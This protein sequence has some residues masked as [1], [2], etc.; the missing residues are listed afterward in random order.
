MRTYNNIQL[1]IFHEST[2]S[3]EWTTNVKKNMDSDGGVILQQIK[4]Q[5]AKKKNVLFISTVFF[6]VRF[7]F[8]KKNEESNEHVYHKFSVNE[9]WIFTDIAK[10]MEN[11]KKKE[12]KKDKTEKPIECLSINLQ[13]TCKQNFVFR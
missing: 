9:L 8:T 11:L 10:W 3:A 6:F 7:I 5:E 1:D 4:Q 13:N 12:K 2:I